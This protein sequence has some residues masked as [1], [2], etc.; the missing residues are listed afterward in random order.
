L[1]QSSWATT[2]HNRSH[3][4]KNVWN[5]GF[6]CPRNADGTWS[7]PP[8][9]DY[10][11]PFSS[12]YVEGDAWQY[13]WFVPQDPVGLVALYEAEGGS[14]YFIEQ[15]SDLFDRSNWDPYNIL[16]NPYYWAGNE[17]S[18]FAGW[19]FDFAGRPDL[20]QKYIR[21]VMDT[22]YSEKPDGLP[23]NDDYG[24]M[25]AW[26]VFGAIGFYP[27]SGNP[28]Y[29]MGSPVFEEVVIRREGGGELTVKA[30]NASRVNIYVQKVKVN[31]KV[32]NYPWFAHEDLFPSNGGNALLEFWMGPNG[33]ESMKADVKVVAEQWEV[34]AQDTMNRVRK[35][36]VMENLN[37]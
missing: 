18:L 19:L 2:F 4:Y 37:N 6:F 16:P 5:S 22:R 33:A 14:G 31:G 11:N 25:S 8:W 34:F 20:T 36:F 12:R 23:G 7:C 9:Y 35:Q 30:Y 26:Y 29:C 21:M 10:A 1:G 13:R 28:V 17:P 3:N 15:L 27:Q 24:T 32:Y